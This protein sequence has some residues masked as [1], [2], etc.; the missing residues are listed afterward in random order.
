MPA[1]MIPSAARSRR[2]ASAVLLVLILAPAMVRAQ[3]SHDDMMLARPGPETYPSLMIRGF[4]DVDYISS[5]GPGGLPQGFDLGQFVLHFTSQLARKVNFVGEVSMT[6]AADQFKVEVERS[7]IRYDYDDEFKI[8]AGRYHTPIGY[9]NTAYHH[10]LWLQ[11]TVRR[12]EQ[13]K[14]G[15]I[16]VPVHFV[17][18]L[19]EGKLP[20]GG[21]GLSYAAGV[22]NGRGDVPS[23]GG[24]AGDANTNRAWITQ[25]LAHPV[26]GLEAGAALYHDLVPEPAGTSSVREWIYSGHLVWTRE[27]PELL[28]E[29]IGV[30]HESEGASTTYDSRSY[31]IQAAY[32]LPGW[33]NKLKPYSRYE[34]MDIAAG[35]P[36]F[37]IPDLQVVT[38][39]LRV[40][41]IDVAAVKIEYR[42][43]LDEGSGRTNSVLLQACLTF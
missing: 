4:T 41:L 8:S 6:P 1:L 10:G 15:G 3:G 5:H 26:F 21:L 12:P 20:S 31:Y 27:S 7:F 39:G 30:R 36:I 9:W 37:K 38:A 40:D 22:G 13:V 24:D 2:G 18:L 43:E 14:F 16:Y 33:A 11:T 42:N 19:A 25:L 28:G 32:R 34:Q 23:R 29:F 17:G 35:D